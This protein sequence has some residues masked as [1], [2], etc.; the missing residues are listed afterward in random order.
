ML[1]CMLE[2]DWGIR[3]AVH[4]ACGSGAFDYLD[5]DSHVLIGQPPPYA[6]FAQQGET[7]TVQ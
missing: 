7:I 1:G 3:T 2:S 5:L 6:G 4:L